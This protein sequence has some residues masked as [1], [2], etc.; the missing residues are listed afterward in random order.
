[1]LHCTSNEYD[2]FILYLLSLQLLH[3]TD[4]TYLCGLHAASS[5]FLCHPM[6]LCLGHVFYQM[7]IKQK[8]L[9]ENYQMSDF[10]ILIIR[11][12]F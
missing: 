5:I 6:M 2:I 3:V 8:D 10:Q 7:K 9:V 1:M 4:S 12:Y 11:L